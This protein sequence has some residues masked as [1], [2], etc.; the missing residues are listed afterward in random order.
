M[1]LGNFTKKISGAVHHKKM[2]KYRALD[3]YTH[4][5]WII[6]I[7]F[8]LATLIISLSLFMFWKI[9]HGEFFLTFVPADTTVETIDRQKL[10]KTVQF[11]ETRRSVFLE[12]EANPAPIIDPGK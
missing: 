3:P 10:D 2:D 1:N 11:F 7:L 9:S 12:E 6:I 5:K 8:T 4:W